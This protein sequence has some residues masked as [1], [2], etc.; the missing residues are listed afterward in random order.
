MSHPVPART[1]TLVRPTPQ[2]ASV[3][4]LGW[5]ALLWGLEVLDTALPFLRLDAWGVS[6]RD[7]AELPQI[8]TA[9]FLHF[10]FGHLI[11]NTVPF[12]VLGLL[13]LLSGVRT[14]VVA[15]LASVVVS[16]LAV[17]LLSAPGTVTAGAS[18]IVFGWLAF[19]LVRGL[20]TAN[21]KH[22]AIGVVVFAVYGGVLWGVFPTMPGVSWLGHLGGAVGGVLAAAYL[23]RRADGGCPGSRRT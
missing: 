5:V 10:G 12:F 1:G 2:G 23:A 14:F 11:A 19:V 4:M 15:T 8:F 20:F 16:G 9:P 17:W 22:L 7:P 18:G 3:F 13:I 21:L 6:P